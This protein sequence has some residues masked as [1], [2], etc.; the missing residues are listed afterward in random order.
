MIKL[1]GKMSETK[2]IW[3]RF[4]LMLF[5]GFVAYLFWHQPDYFRRIFLGNEFSYKLVLPGWVI[6]AIAFYMLTE[7]IPGIGYDYEKDEYPC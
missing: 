7:F 6:F 4:V 5:L 2:A 1:G 3:L